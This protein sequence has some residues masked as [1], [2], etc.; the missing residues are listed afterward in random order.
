MT[1]P[2]QLDGDGDGKPDSKDAFDKAWRQ[3]VFHELRTWRKLMPWALTT[4]HSQGYP[5]PEI[6]AIFNG[7]GIGF[8]T[9]DVIEGKKPFHE[10]W[11]YYNAWCTVTVKPAI[12]SVESAVPDQ[13]AYGYDYSPQ[14][15]MPPSTWSFA[16]DYY[17]YMRFGLA[18]TLMNDGYFSHELGDTDHGQ[19]WWYDELDFKLGAP[20][21]PAR[22]VA[23]SQGSHHELISNG[24]F[25]DE[26]EDTWSLWC[27]RTAGCRATVSRDSSTTHSGKAAARV[28]V[29]SA[30]RTGGIEFTQPRRSIK[31]GKNYALTFWAR[32]DQPMEITCISS[33]G[34]PGW[35]NYGLNR[36]VSLTD[37]WKAVQLT[38]EATRTADDARIQFLC[39]GETGTFWL[40]D[41]SLSEG[42]D[43][44]Y[45]RE[46]ENGLVLLN[47]TRRRQT[48]DAGEGYARLKG[49]QA[50]RYQYILDDR[51]N[52]GFKT[53]G[54]WRE[55]AMGTKEWH[56]IPPYFHAWNNRCHILDGATGEATW[57]L[58]L[59]G[60]G[61][62]TIQAWWAAAPGA[63]DW[64]RR[65]VYEVLADG[66]I[67]ASKTLD[68]TKT[69]DEWHTIA[70]GL[71]LAPGEHPVVRLRNGGQGTLVADAL[72]VFSAERY[73]DGTVARQVTLEPMDGIVLRRIT[74]APR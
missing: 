70:E 49:E 73:N 7:Q 40:D 52:P 13:I 68:Q 4:G 35:D 59:R 46:F 14:R 32:A 29:Q 15:H 39:G 44:I 31:K 41:I 11:D 25:E 23:V 60:P 2:V 65:A 54:A 63:K 51:G 58:D 26:L 56:A 8:Y 28:N 48:I 10:L 57:D 43:E 64:T 45:R 47:G 50:A 3:G 62:Y 27:D 19:D 12:T 61:T 55:V 67:I 74:P 20:L 18:F 9:T 33:K 42:A 24:G 69:G 38:F 34:S 71:K 21:G 30:G 16:R 1:G 36:N 53:N 72:H 5:H 37:Q 22:A 6:A 66:Q 17:P